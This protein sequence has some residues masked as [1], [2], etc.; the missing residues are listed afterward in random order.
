MK[1]TKSERLFEEFAQKK[2]WNISKIPKSLNKS[3]D[4][5]VFINYKRMIFEIKEIVE[6]EDDKRNKKLLKERGYSD[7]ISKTPGQYVRAKIISAKNQL[8]EFKELKIPMLVALYDNSMNR[9]TKLD[10]YELL[11]GMYGLESVILALPQDKHQAPYS[12]GMKYGTK[13]QTNRQH[14]TSISA[15]AVIIEKDNNLMLDILY[16]NQF[17]SVPLTNYDISG[18][19]IS[20]YR[21]A[22]G[23]EP[24]DR[25]TWEKSN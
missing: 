19:N 12:V 14:N 10:P 17:A 9:I 4:Y 3:P 2:G 16:H 24:F 18:E 7:V 25:P 15:L 1:H 8:K 23:N 22:C 21:L 13:S 11:V 6:N 20:H 5:D